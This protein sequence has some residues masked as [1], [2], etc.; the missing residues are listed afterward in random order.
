MDLRRLIFRNILWRGLYFISA[1]ILNIVIARLLNAD[2]S[3][4]VFYIINN[5]SFTLLVV[6]LSLE[7]GATYY[8]AKK[9]IDNSKI[10]FFLLIW[11]LAG[12]AISV[13][14]FQWIIPDSVYASNSSW[15]Y[16]MGC[17]SYISGFLF[18]TYFSAL[19]FAKHNFFVS[20]FILFFINLLLI[21][22]FILTRN[23]S[24]VHDH[25]IIIYFGS[26]FLQGLVLILIY[27][28]KNVS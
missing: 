9:D 3:G 10:A 12:T 5:L 15:E 14:F 6:G 1:F 26:F 24:F 18:I 28:L 20:N 27:F 17:I 19:F 2:G 16:F 21:A 8:I 13:L 25:F 4:E 22:F 11:S 23:L 7:S